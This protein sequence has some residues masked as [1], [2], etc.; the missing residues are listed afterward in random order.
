MYI[1]LFFDVVK[2]VSLFNVF[3][4]LI[5]GVPLS[6]IVEGTLRLRMVANAV[7]AVIVG[8]GSPLRMEN[9]S[10]GSCV[11]KRRPMGLSQ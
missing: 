3:G 1:P 8:K 2:F 6:S 5:V 9:I 11:Y 4:V 10:N 7:I